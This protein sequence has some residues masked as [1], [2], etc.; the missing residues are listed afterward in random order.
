MKT[1]VHKKSGYS[2]SILE[3]KDTESTILKSYNLSAD[4]VIIYSGITPPDDWAEFRYIFDGETWSFEASDYSTKVLPSLLKSPLGK[5][6][7]V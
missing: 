4:D 1:I 6:I 7:K 2:I 5:A 3:D